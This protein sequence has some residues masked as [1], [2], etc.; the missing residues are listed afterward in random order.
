MAPSWWSFVSTLTAK[1]RAALPSKDFALPGRKYPIEDS[2]HAANAKARATQQ[3]K[4]GKL[5][6][7][8]RATVDRRA[9]AVLHARTTEKSRN[10]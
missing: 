2:R 1:Q 3:F 4:E 10:R 9:D 7:A 5:S 8:D 6:A